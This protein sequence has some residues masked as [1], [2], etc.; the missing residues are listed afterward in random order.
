MKILIS[1]NSSWNVVNF[2]LRLIKSLVEQGNLVIIAAPKDKYSNTIESLGVKY[3]NF[4]INSHSTNLFSEIYLLFRFI[5]LYGE[6][7]PD[8]VLAFTSK[9]NIYGSIAASFWRIPIVNNIA[10]LGTAF[11]KGG[12]I[13]KIVEILYRIT[14]KG[15]NKVFFQNAEDLDLFIKKNII[16]RKKTGLLPGSGVDLKK[17]IPHPINFTLNKSGQ[18]NVQIVFLLIARLLKEKGIME[19]VEASRIVKSKLPNVKIALLGFIDKEN[20]NSFTSNQ[21][22]NWTAQGLVEYWGESDD[23]RYQIALAD[24]VV[25]PSYREGT[26]RVLLEAAAMGRPLIATNVPGCR[27]IVINGYNGLLCKEKSPEDLA[28]KMISMAQQSTQNIVKWGQNSRTLVEMKFDESIVVNKYLNEI[29]EIRIN[30]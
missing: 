15:T 10:G 27:E 17:F 25:L 5:K 3:I 8:V 29:S 12:T 18:E 11:I 1:I 26:P 22:E 20:P 28:E 23:V 19:Y 16:S 13:K 2:R 7:R 24:C 4:P 30:R 14:L 9:P 6:E 21:I